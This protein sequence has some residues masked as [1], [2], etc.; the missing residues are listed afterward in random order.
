MRLCEYDY[1]E[2]THLIMGTSS[3]FCLRWNN[4]QTNL[5]RAFDDLLR[6]ESFTDVTLACEDGVTLKAH[7]LVLA[8]CSAYFSSLFSSTSP[9]QHPIVILKD[10]HSIEMRALLQYMYRGEVN[11]E[12]NHLKELLRVAEGLRVKGLVEDLDSNTQTQPL[13]L[14]TSNSQ[15]L[16]LLVT[17]S[18]R[19][20]PDVTP[21][22]TPLE[23][24]P[25]S[26]CNEGWES[27]SFYSSNNRKSFHSPPPS[28]KR[29]KVD[30][31]EEPHHIIS[32]HVAHELHK[33]PYLPSYLS[34][35]IHMN[36]SQ[37]ISHPAFDSKESKPLRDSYDGERESAA[38]I[39]L[40]STSNEVRERVSP[41]NL[42]TGSTPFSVPG[43]DS[44]PIKRPKPSTE[45][46]VISPNPILRTALAHT[47]NFQQDVT[48]LA[49]FA[50]SM[51]P[52]PPLLSARTHSI[53]TNEELRR[54]SESH[55]ETYESKF[56]HLNSDI[57]QTKIQ[58]YVD[59]SRE[60][61]NG[62]KVVNGA[63]MSDYSSYNLDPSNH[64]HFSNFVSYVPTAKPEW[65]R[66]KQY[67]KADL[68]QA[69]DAVR[70][71]MT[72]LQASRKYKVPSRTLYDKIKKMGINTLPRRLP[73]KKTTTTEF[74]LDVNDISQLHL[75]TSNYLDGRTSKGE[76]NCDR[77]DRVDRVS[78]GDLTGNP[79]L[80]NV[81]IQASLTTKESKLEK[82]DM[83]EE[84]P[85][86]DEDIMETSTRGSFS[87]V[88]T[89]VFPSDDSGPLDLTDTDNNTLTS[90]PTIEERA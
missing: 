68:S 54:A 10:V 56:F 65:K 8:A 45:Q 64:S 62:E 89:K 50:N 6:Q 4:H 74:G 72:A 43:P 86:Q 34:Q 15:P 11:V 3:Q 1:L 25:S 52:L 81:H 17:P 39:P 46:P 20:T 66:Y 33:H 32:D 77:V 9:S 28:P 42:S 63:I 87:F 31:K 67:T 40:H 60:E 58:I 88:G 26:N 82:T 84:C 73:S 12:Q 49:S 38:D 22:P 80:P 18:Q 14:L 75:Q 76:F 59:I 29:S 41:S 79:S 70:K 44:P 69:I 5:L 19:Y 71:G 48:S 85:S 53:A 78:S 57:P 24:R 36:H 7:R 2:E 47:R 35:H 13:P 27:E 90:R 61:E 83:Q 51:M 55:R 30:I 16:P 23:N 37:R 21:S